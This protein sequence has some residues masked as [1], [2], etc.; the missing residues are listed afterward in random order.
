MS[1]GHLLLV[2]AFAAGVVM[3][4]WASRIGAGGES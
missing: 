1:F 3:V 2:T 4:A